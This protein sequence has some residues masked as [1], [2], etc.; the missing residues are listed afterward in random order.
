MELTTVGSWSPYPRTGEACSGYILEERAARI[1][2]DCGHGV[3]S[4]LGRY[5]DP[6]Q[7]DA[8]FI[9]HFHP[10]HCAD[11]QALR[12][13]M[14]GAFIKGQRT[15]PLKV[16]LPDDNQGDLAYWQQI[17]E[18]EI[19]I[20]QDKWSYHLSDIKLSFHLMSHSILTYGIKAET[21]QSSFFY[22]AD[23]SLDEGLVEASQ[24]VDLLLAE[25]TFRSFEQDLAAATGHM[26]T[27]DAAYWAQKADAGKLLAGHFWPGFDQQ[28]LR[29]D[30]AALY[31]GQFEMAAAGLKLQI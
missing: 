6:L 28:E 2:L 14:R 7:L 22:T 27:A 5:M 10:D 23:T 29:A 20:V 11:L 25:T 19:I 21:E 12:H 30:L 17:K 13:F 4:H 3:F 18:V 8:V 26:T 24:G 31:E 15:R 16:F 9:S 1:L